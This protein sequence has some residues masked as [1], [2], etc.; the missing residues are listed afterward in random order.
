VPDGL[1]ARESPTVEPPWL[2]VPTVVLGDGGLHAHLLV[3]RG[4]MPYRRFEL[5]GV[6]RPEAWVQSGAIAW[7]ALLVIGFAQRVY[8]TP[9]AAASPRRIDLESYFSG[10]SAGDEWLL[11]I[12]GSDVLRLDERGDVVWRSEEFGI[13]GVVIERVANGTIIGQYAYEPPDGWSPFAL[14]LDG[15]RTLDPQ[16]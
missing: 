9:A 13:D 6:G 12:S 14:A 10:F 11:V 16:R 7:K 5:R 3:E 4:G 8:V 1:V 2:D 15:G